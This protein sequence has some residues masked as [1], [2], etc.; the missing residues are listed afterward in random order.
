MHLYQ[1]EIGHIVSKIF[2]SVRVHFQGPKLHALCYR[3][4]RKDEKLATRAVLLQLVLKDFVASVFNLAFPKLGDFSVAGGADLGEAVGTRNGMKSDR[5]LLF[6]GAAANYAAKIIAGAGALRI[7]EELFQSLPD[8]LQDIC[9]L[10]E[11]G[12][13]KIQSQSRSELDD[14]LEKYNIEWDR[15]ESTERIN[16]DKR[17][18]PL[19]SIEYSD[20]TALIDLDALGISNNKRVLAASIYAD[21][22]G[23]TVYVDDARGTDRE[24]E[25]LRVFHAIRREMARVVRDDYKALRIQFQGDR[26]QGYFICPKMMKR[27]SQW[28][29]SKSRRRFRRVLH[30]R[31]KRFCPKPSRSIWLLVLIWGERWYLSW[32]PTRTGIASAWAKRCNGQQ[33]VKS[34]LAAKKSASPRRST[35]CCPPTCAPSSPGAPERDATLRRNCEPTFWKPFVAPANTTAINLSPSERRQTV[36]QL[37][38]RLLRQ[39]RQRPS[40][41]PRA[42]SLAVKTSDDTA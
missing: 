29:P 40:F 1:R 31:S 26:L 7:T 24:E 19:P 14:L 36:R 10:C 21:V 20:A 16:D 13:Y 8:D 34:A 39:Q 22:T 42:R 38:A 6:L 28:K 3:P 30:L 37:S 35:T 15:D 2:E 32:A 27:P 12:H 25:A 23:F 41:C 9:D 5:E 18:F 33:S 17:A 4:I 11:D